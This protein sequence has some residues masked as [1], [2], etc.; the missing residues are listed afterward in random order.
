MIQEVVGC[1]QI[2][3]SFKAIFSD[4]LVR[5]MNVRTES[6]TSWS[7]RCVILGKFRI[8][9]D[10]RAMSPVPYHAHIQTVFFLRTTLSSYINAWS[11]SLSAP[12]VICSD[13][14]EISVSLSSLVEPCQLVGSSRG[15]LASV[16]DIR[17]PCIHSE[18]M[19]YVRLESLKGNNPCIPFQA[20][21]LRRNTDFIERMAAFY[22]GVMIFRV[23][24]FS[25]P[26]P[27]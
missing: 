23:L 3:D 18:N 17:H 16:L 21:G 14:S 4:Q 20:A 10:N 13:P 27:V 8:T 24:P 6:S 12:Y 9:H 26:M 7:K 1:V 11:S 19:R 5:R 2:V 15:T 22:L 25:F